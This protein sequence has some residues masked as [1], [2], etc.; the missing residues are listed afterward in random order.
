MS[1]RAYPQDRK[2]KT[3]SERGDHV[4]EAQR[5]ASVLLA[6][7]RKRQRDAGG[8]LSRA[9]KCNVTFYGLARRR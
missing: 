8:T 9:E 5:A 1:P 2:E 7:F 4:H 3:L 6:K